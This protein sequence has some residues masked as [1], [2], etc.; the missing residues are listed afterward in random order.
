MT[1]ILIWIQTATEMTFLQLNQPPI[2]YSDVH[3]FCGKLTQCM[4]PTLNSALQ[5]FEHGNTIEIHNLIM[6]NFYPGLPHI[7]IYIYIL[8]KLVIILRTFASVD[9]LS[10]I[11]AEPRPPTM[12]ETAWTL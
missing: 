9:Y 5:R 3:T 1:T 2:F 12:T 6:F 10:I 7:Y 8:L 11:I 4:S